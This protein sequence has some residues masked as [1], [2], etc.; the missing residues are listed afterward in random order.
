MLL[1][2]RPLTLDDLESQ[3]A[4]ELPDRDLMQVIIIPGGLVN[5]VVGDVTVNVDLRDVNVGANVCV[6][7][8][9]SQSSVTCEV[10]QR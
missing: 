10:T 4:L 1:E 5:V 7:A 9:A 2:K 8:I 6:Q 3:A